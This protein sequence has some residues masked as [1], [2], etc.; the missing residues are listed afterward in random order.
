MGLPK[1]AAM[2]GRS[3]LVPGQVKS[4]EDARTRATA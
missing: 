3:L 4:G 1:P 2:T